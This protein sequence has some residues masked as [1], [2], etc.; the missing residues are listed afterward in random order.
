MLVKESPADKEEKHFLDSAGAIQALLQSFPG[1]DRLYQPLELIGSGS[2]SAVFKAL[3]VRHA[4]FQQ[5]TPDSNN[6]KR[7]RTRLQTGQQYVA[8]K[9]VYAFAAPWRIYNELE[10]LQDIRNTGVKQVLSIVTAIRHF[11]QILI[12]L[13]FI[14]HAEFRDY[15]DCYPL[16][17]IACYLR[18]LLLACHAIHT[19]GIVHRDIKP[20]NYCW[21]PYIN[22]G[23]LVDFGLAQYEDMIDEGIPAC[24]CLN[25]QVALL[26][27]HD[28]EEQRSRMRPVGELKNDR[29]RSKRGERGGTRGFRAPEVLLRC[30]RQSTAIDVWSTGIILLCFL[31]QRMPFFCAEDDLV[32]FVELCNVFGTEEMSHCATVHGCLLDINLPGVPVH[33]YAWQHLVKSLL[34]MPSLEPGAYPW[35]E[36]GDDILLQQAFDFLDKALELDPFHR[37]TAGELLEHPFLQC[38]YLS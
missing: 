25:E 36:E 6:G 15:F 23:V 24:G 29:R 21:N 17:N 11:D 26:T 20:G 33:R 13:P 4:S 19:L 27:T 14:Q 32:A 30:S 9:Q 7:Y 3:D 2:F 38:V 35:L 28:I 18:D 1:I 8:I 10:V 12:V 16:R 34:G 22:Q 37:H 5:T 31:C